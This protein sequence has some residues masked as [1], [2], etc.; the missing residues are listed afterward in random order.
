MK[1]T[2][3]VL[4][5]LSMAMLVSSCAKK[6]E[7]KVLSVPE[8]PAKEES[9]A[10]F[11]PGLY[12]P[13]D[14]ETGPCV[15]FEEETKRLHTAASPAVSYA[16]RGTYEVHGT[17]ITGTAGKADVLE[18]EVLPENKIRL[19]KVHYE[20]DSDVRYDWLKEG[21]EYVLHRW[22]EPRFGTVGS[23]DDALA[24]SKQNGVVVTEDAALTSGKEIMEKF[25]E[26]ARNGIPSS[27]VIASYYTLDKE[28]VSAEL[29]EEEKDQ[30]PKLFFRLAEY[31]GTQ[32]IVY[33]RDCTKEE[34][35]TAE[36]YMHLLHLAGDMP[37]QAKHK[38]YDNYVLTDEPDVTWE[39]IFRGIVSSQS[40]DWIR[41][42]TLIFHLY[43]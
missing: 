5:V 32:Y 4:I 18:Y 42:H 26:D 22:V 38:H 35:E 14:N 23:A 31:N 40:T 29:Y 12:V 36:G 3:C 33:T 43:D 9:A 16:A 13:Q 10:V 24:W 15:V 21:D 1:K 11:V 28:R 41:H 6:E 17:K 8:E 25:Y 30:Y 27:V 37:L 2:V 39:E 19:T 34:I 20:P 7:E